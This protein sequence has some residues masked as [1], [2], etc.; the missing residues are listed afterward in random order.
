[1]DTSFPHGAPALNREARL[2]V[3]VSAREMRAKSMRANLRLP[4]GFELVSG[5][6][7]WMGD[8]A[9]GNKVDVITAI[10]RA[11]KEGSWTL[12][13]TFYIDPKEHGFFGTPEEGARFPIYVLIS[14]SSAEWRLNPPYDAAPLIPQPVRTP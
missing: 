8:V 3:T 4:E 9:Q 12:W 14:E 11:V 13:T 7:S 5:N 1:M 10:V 6:L 2:I